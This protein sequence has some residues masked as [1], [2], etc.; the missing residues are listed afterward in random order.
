MI[1]DR[2]PKRE[3]YSSQ[4]NDKRVVQ[5]A[6]DE[7]RPDGEQD[8]QIEG[9]NHD[10]DA[11]NDNDQGKANGNDG[12]NNPP[13]NGSAN[14]R[15]SSFLRLLLTLQDQLKTFTQAAIKRCIYRPATA[16][17]ESRR[18]AFLNTLERSHD[19]IQIHIGI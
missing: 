9:G 1:V 5:N 12:R 15:P 19:T 8:F 17:A 7:Q 4:C 11:A 18:Q 3:H 14:F 6:H 13:P 10:C 16:A 2:D